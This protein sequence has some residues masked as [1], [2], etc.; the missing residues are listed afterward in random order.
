MKGSFLASLLACFG[1]AG[2][3]HAASPWSMYAGDSTHAGRSSASGASTPNLA[4]T[5]SVGVRAQDNASPVVGPDRTIYVPTESGFFAINPNGTLKWKK[6]DTDATGIRQAPAVASNGTVYVAHYWDQKLYALNPT[7]GVTLWSYP[8]GYTSYGSPAIDTNGTIYIGNAPFGASSMYAINPNGTLKWQWTSGSGC[9]IESSPAIGLNGEIYFHHNCLGLVALSSTG[10][11]LWSRSDLG[12]SFNSPS[13]G[14]DGTIYIGNSDYHFYALNPNGT[15]KWQVA[16]SNWMYEASASISADGSK[17]Y[18]GDNGGK[19]YAFSSFGSNVWQFNT[20]ISSPIYSAPALTANGIVYFTQE[21]SDTSLYALRA[22]NGSLL[23]SY[24]IGASDASPAIGADGTL[25][26]L[27]KNTSGNAVLYAFAPVFRI[28]SVRREADNIRITW[29]AEAGQN[30][31][32]QAMSG[33]AGCSFSNNFTDVSPTI[34]V[35]GT[36][37]TITNY[38]ETGGATNGQARYYRVRLAP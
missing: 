33:G 23:W 32:L 2:P 22:V 16:V 29:M 4:W 3:L 14:P 30:F 13:V 15:N 12:Q 7:N 6:W 37:L 1:F 18:R 31:V 8:I 21:S 34:A 9:W 25:Y 26:A 27:G 17:I 11:K 38:V 28:A 36:G 24:S 35:P 5:Y 19:F 10:S 20:G